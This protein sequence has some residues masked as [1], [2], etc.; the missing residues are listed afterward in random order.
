MSDANLTERQR[1]WFAS[2]REGLE[3]DTAKSLAEW[4]E[5]ARTCPESGHRARL[6]W[7]K[8]NHGLLQNRASQVIGEAFGSAMAWTE[9][10]SLVDA[11]W[12]EPAS[13]A[14]FEALDARASGLPE[15][16]R[17]ARKTYTAWSR[18]VQFAAMRPLKSGKAILGLAAPPGS[19]PRLGPRGSESW[20]DRL[21]SKLLL[22]SPHEVDDEVEECLRVAWERA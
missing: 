10:E 22:G 7:F 11:L 16:I 17:T 4:V 2:V 9:P 13:R 14:I 18:N 20:S 12:S 5:I 6:K 15:V 1:K 21:N 19:R 3:R 8:V